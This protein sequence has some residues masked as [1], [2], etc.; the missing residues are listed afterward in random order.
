MIP[1]TPEQ[2]WA[3][4]A[5]FALAGYLIWQGLQICGLRAEAV[6][7]LDV[8]P[9]D[10]DLDPFGYI[11]EETDRLRDQQVSDDHLEDRHG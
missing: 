10:R 3:Y 7:D 1:M 4:L 8:D 9:Y 11:D 5:C 6:D 2:S